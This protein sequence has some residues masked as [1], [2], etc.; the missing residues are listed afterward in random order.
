M[1]VCIQH[2]EGRLHANPERAPLLGR[3]RDLRGIPDAGAPDRARDLARQGAGRCLEPHRGS[4]CH[5]AELHSRADG[6]HISGG[7]GELHPKRGILHSHRGPAGLLPGLR[8]G[9]R[10]RR[11]LPLSDPEPDQAPARKL[12]GNRARLRRRDRRTP[13]RRPSP[14]ILKQLHRQRHHLPGS[15]RP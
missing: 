11:I 2:H 10:L 12:H 13:R 6:S 1:V 15:R 7:L 4:L 8:V 9:L 3:G 14:I 5:G